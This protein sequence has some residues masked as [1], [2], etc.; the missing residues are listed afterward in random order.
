VE[1][2]GRRPEHSIEGVHQDLDRVALDRVAGTAR[3]LAPRHELVEYLAQ[4]TLAPRE[5]GTV[6]SHDRVFFRLARLRSDQVQGVD[7]E[8]ADQARVEALEVEHDDVRVEAGARLE[9]VPACLGLHD[10]APRADARRHD[11]QRRY[12]EGGGADLPFVD[13]VPEIRDAFHG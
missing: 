8:G 13:C 10:L 7:L 3:L 1:A 12:Q 11:A 6:W 5:G 4:E 9:H 2:A